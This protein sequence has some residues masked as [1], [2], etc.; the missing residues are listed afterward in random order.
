MLKKTTSLMLNKPCKAGLRDVQL[1]D[2]HHRFASHAIQQGVPLPVI[3]KL[4]EHSNMR[5][6]LRYVHVSDQ[7]IKTAAEQIGAS[8]ME[9]LSRLQYAEIPLTINDH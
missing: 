2:L 5:M 4:M 6:A 7:E 9:L 8:M 1:H 3:S